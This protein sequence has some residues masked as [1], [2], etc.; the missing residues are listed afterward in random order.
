MQLRKLT[1]RIPQIEPQ[2]LHELLLILRIVFVQLD[3]QILDRVVPVGSG[4]TL[5]YLH[6]LET[7]VDV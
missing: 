3:V 5:L 4:Q 6:V 7:F 2:Q 1:T